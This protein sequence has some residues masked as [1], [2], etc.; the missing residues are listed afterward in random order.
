MW[1]GGLGM[2]MECGLWGLRGGSVHV[3]E[4]GVLL[5]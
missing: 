2:V 4:F 5:V 1:K 3:Y